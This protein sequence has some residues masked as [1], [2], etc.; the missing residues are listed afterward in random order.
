VNCGCYP[1]GKSP[2][3]GNTLMKHIGDRP[4]GVILN[5]EAK[6][7]TSRGNWTADGRELP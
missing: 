7:R 2:K 4:E 5:T 3:L 1:K 6:G